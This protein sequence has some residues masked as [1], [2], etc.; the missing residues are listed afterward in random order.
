MQV[1]AEEDNR[2]R[3]VWVIDLLPNE[4]VGLIAGNMDKAMPIMKQ[5]LEASPE[6]LP[7]R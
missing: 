5:T 4:F 3:L 1:F 6:Y 2:S 7:S